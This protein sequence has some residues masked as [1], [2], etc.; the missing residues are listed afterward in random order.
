MTLLDVAA[1]HDVFTNPVVPENA[2]ERSDN[3]AHD[4][5]KGFVSEGRI[6]FLDKQCKENRGVKIVESG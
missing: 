4:S 3:L 6:T 2:V 5:K 1:S